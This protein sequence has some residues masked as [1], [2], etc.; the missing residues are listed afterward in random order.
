MLDFY[1]RKHPERLAKGP[2]IYGNVLIDPTAKIHINCVIG[3][4]VVI[5]P[6]C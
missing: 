4:D 3:P 5:G 2:N 6:G 1:R